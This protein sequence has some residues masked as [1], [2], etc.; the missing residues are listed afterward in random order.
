MSIAADRSDRSPRVTH[1]QA[2]RNFSHDSWP[3]GTGL[4]E[5]SPRSAPDRDGRDH[6]S[7]MRARH[8][9]RHDSDRNA[10]PGV[11]RMRRVEPDE[12]KPTA[13]QESTSSHGALSGRSVRF[14]SGTISCGLSPSTHTRPT[15]IRTCSASGTFGC[16]ERAR[17]AWLHRRRICHTVGTRTQPPVQSPVA[18]LL[19]YSERLLG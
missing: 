12:H 15:I 13:P 19:S 4:C 6:A 8:P 1:C 3:R 17:S 2:I 7:C 9:H 11:D 18:T 14:L 5:Y 16:T 10:G